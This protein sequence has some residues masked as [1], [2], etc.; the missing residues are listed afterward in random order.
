MANEDRNKAGN[1]GATGIE[2]ELAELRA[3][4]DKVD[5]EILARLNERARAVQR[6]GEI[7]DGGRKGPIWK[8][9]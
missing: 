9:F 8:D 6:V 5:G 4:I 2:A 1:D 7:K 3:Q